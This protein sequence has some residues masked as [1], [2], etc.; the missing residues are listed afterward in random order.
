MSMCSASEDNKLDLL[1][2]MLLQIERSWSRQANFPSSYCALKFFV[3][4]IYRLRVDYRLCD[5][6]QWMPLRVAILCVL[7]LPI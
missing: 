7:P 1:I 3:L 5:W 2:L 6:W 4:L